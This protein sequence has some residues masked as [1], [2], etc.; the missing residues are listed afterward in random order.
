MTTNLDR[1][2][3]NW[4]FQTKELIDTLPLPWTR[5]LLYFLLIFVSI[6]LPWAIFSKVDE[7]SVWPGKLEPQG[8]TVKLD[9]ITAGEVE[10]IYVREE[11]RGESRT[12]DFNP[13]F[14]INRQGNTTNRGENRRTKKPSF[15]TETCQKSVRDFFHHPKPT[16]S[17]GG[18]QKKPRSNKRGRMWT[19]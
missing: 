13:R 15:P 16:K 10:K 2:R 18:R 11:P 9:A 12:T 14:L 4:S 5:G 7:T 8:E 17:R 6:I 1:E 19:H 3:D